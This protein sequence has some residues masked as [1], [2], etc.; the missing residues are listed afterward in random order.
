VKKKTNI[1]ETASKASVGERDTARQN[2][3]AVSAK[4]KMSLDA[5]REAYA[6]AKQSIKDGFETTFQKEFDAIKAEYGKDAGND[7]GG[8][9]YTP[10]NRTGEERRKIRRALAEERK[11]EKQ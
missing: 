9:G 7:S 8:G 6:K 10:P 5:T 2:R 3:E 1:R 4:V 11:H